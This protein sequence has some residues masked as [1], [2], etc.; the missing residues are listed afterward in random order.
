MTGAA[1]ILFDMPPRIDRVVFAVGAVDAVT[2]ALVRDGVSARIDGLPDQPIVNGSGLLVFIN[3]P[4]RPQ[5]E[6]EVDGR[7]AGFP[8]VERFTFTPP[9]A[10][11]DDPAACRHDV[12]L[13][14]GPAYPFPS[15]TTL[16]RGVVR[17]GTAGVDGAT[18]SATSIS[19]GTAFET[20]SVADGGFALALRLPPLG[21]H[22]AEA[23]VPVT[24]AVSDQGQ[25]RSFMRPLV[26]GRC[27][28]F[29]EPIDLAGTNDP[30][31]FET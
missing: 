12:L 4:D 23:P 21:T 20:R 30:G 25:S 27:H 5:Y 6:V 8:H 11:K 24:L 31:L 15:G 3:L 10:G 14:P 9:A 19:G 17:R 1:T 22:E 7:G 29:L 16:V 13:T 28:S 18:V 2:G 26:N